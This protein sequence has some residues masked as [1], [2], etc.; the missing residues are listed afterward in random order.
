[1]SPYL[2]IIILMKAK[3]CLFLAC[4]TQADDS[5]YKFRVHQNFMQEV[6]SKNIRTL[7]DH[8]DEMQMKSA[9]LPTVDTVLERVSLKVVSQSK[10]LVADLLLDDTDDS[11]V[12]DLQG[13]TLKGMALA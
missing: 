4:L 3:V 5:I 10:I 12:L 6:F 9:Y 11:L 1:M 13:L 8:T 7:L 2:L